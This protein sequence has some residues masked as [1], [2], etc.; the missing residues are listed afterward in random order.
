MHKLF[1]PKK[2]EYKGIK[3]WKGNDIFLSLK[4]RD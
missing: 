1:I 3:K 2:N 4:K